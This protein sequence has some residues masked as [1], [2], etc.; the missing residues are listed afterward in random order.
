MTGTKS[1]NSI[2]RFHLN[3]LGDTER[4]STAEIIKE[5]LALNRR[6]TNDINLTVKGET[7]ERKTRN[8]RRQEKTITATANEKRQEE[9]RHQKSEIIAIII[10]SEL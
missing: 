1:K 4:K 10:A 7:N 3:D 6:E 9:I 5:R 2:R 8:I